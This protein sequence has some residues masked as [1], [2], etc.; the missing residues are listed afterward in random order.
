MG[1][2]V[3]Y[4]ANMREP[5]YLSEEAYLKGLGLVLHP[6][7]I[8]RSPFLL[9]D[10]RR[11]LDQIGAILRR[12]AI[13]LLHCHT[14][15]GGVL[16]RLAG[17]LAPEPGPVVLY[18]AHGFHF[19]KGAPFLNRTAYWE[20]ERTLASLTDILIVINEEDYRSARK[21]RLKKNG[22]VY[23]IPGVGLDARVFRPLTPEQRRDGRGRLGIR[24]EDFFL[25]SVGELNGNKNHRVVLEA[26]AM[27][28][29]G[30]GDLS[31]IR[32]GI[33]GDG[34]YRGRLERQIAQL[35]LRD[36]VTL[37]GYCRR[38][39]DILGCA[40]ASAFPSIREGLGMAGLEALAMGIPLL[41]A[42]NRG[43]REYMEH[44]RTGFVCPPGDAEGFLKG[45]EAL[46]RM[47]PKEKE[48]MR[49]FCLDAVRPFALPYAGAMMRR[50]YADAERRIGGDARERNR[51]VQRHYGR[52]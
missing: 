22:A 49:R 5:A 10:N 8:A 30:G 51:A 16:G 25:V 39:P 34:V 21:F 32:Y 36:T 17:R 15:V 19:Y 38:V 44:G 18:T 40:D 37:Y 14:P 42:D 35:D 46:R 12:Y 1:Y 4:A 41:A 11:A 7:D 3:H 28:R 23:K 52:I 33:C 9:R 26:L 47:G 24:E 45:I 43:T 6:L 2:T 50:I 31:S 48:R 29:E 13:R 27:L 20:V